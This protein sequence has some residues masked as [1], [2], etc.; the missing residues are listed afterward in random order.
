MQN[1]EDDE[2]TGPEPEIENRSQVIV[3]DM[4]KKIVGGNERN[5]IVGGNELKLH[6]PSSPLPRPPFFSRF[7]V[8]LTSLLLC[9]RSFFFF[10]FFCFTY[11]Y[12]GEMLIY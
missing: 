12:S 4:N 9:P 11:I 7:P 1:D 3:R 8:L 10:F 2:G 6:L 5:E